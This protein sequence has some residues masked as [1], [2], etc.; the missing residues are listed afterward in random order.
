MFL[1][2]PRVRP[3][4][5]Q[6]F[7]LLEALVAATVVAVA[8]SV[9]LAGLGG[10]GRTAQRVDE[11]TVA[12]QL[13]VSVLDQFALNP[14]NEVNDADD[15]V[16]GGVKYGYKLTFDA[17]EDTV[18]LPISVLRSGQTLMTVRVQVFWGQQPKLH[19][20]TLSSVLF[21]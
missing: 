8:F 10:V 1:V 14:A 6:G 13:A 11:L 2:R 21:K 16:Y 3:V 19:T 5:Q 17:M 12:R 4:R 15:L 20:Y 9:I 7:T 18:P